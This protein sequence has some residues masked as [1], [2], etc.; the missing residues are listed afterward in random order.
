MPLQTMLLLRK[1]NVWVCFNA[2]I[3]CVLFRM[4]RPLSLYWCAYNTSLYKMASK[5]R[6]DRRVVSYHTAHYT[7]EHIRQYC[8]GCLLCTVY[9]CLWCKLCCIWGCDAGMCIGMSVC[10][11]VC[12]WVC[13]CDCVFVYRGRQL[14]L[15]DH[16]AIVS[17][18]VALWG[19][20]HL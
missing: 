7:R 11:G 20:R 13:V 15:F 9:F 1:Y 10:V 5:Y 19:D 14:L 18:A 6:E 2:L 12:E 8:D 16:L 4:C 3:A 17:C